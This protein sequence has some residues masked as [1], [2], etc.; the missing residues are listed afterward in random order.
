MT[1]RSASEKH[2]LQICCSRFVHMIWLPSCTAIQCQVCC[3][4]IAHNAK[5][6]ANAMTLCFAS[7]C[8]RSHAEICKQAQAQSLIYRQELC[9]PQFTFRAATVMFIVL[10]VQNCTCFSGYTLDK[11]N[12]TPSCKPSLVPSH[13]SI[14]ITVLVVVPAL[15]IVFL[16]LDALGRFRR[17]SYERYVLRWVRRRGPPGWHTMQSCGDAELQK[18]W[19]LL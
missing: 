15:V 8:F 18:A 6:G 4:T 7:S 3:C 19:T 12:G 10:L 5:Q 9:Q 17:G 11:G 13:V 1:I 16:L 14:S 2:R